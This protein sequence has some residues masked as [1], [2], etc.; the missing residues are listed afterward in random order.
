MRISAGL[1]RAD[2]YPDFVREGADEVFCGYVPLAWRERHGD[3]PL[4]RR[5]VHYAHVQIGAKAEMLILRDMVRTLGVPAA[6]TFN[7][8]S[9]PPALYREVE[10]CME[11]CLGMGF[12]SFLVADPFFLRYLHSGG[13]FSRAAV[14]LSGEC[15]A[16]NPEAARLAREAGIRRLVFPRHMTLSEMEACI[17]QAPGMEYEAFVLNEL[18]HFHGAWCVSLHGDDMGYACQIPC[19]PAGL[20][21]PVPVPVEKQKPQSGPGSSGC[22]LCALDRLADIGVTHLKLV[23][24]GALTEDMLRDLRLLRRCRDEAVS[25]RPHEAYAAFVM[26]QFPQGCPRACYYPELMPDLP[27]SVR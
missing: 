19:R 15:G 13:F 2:D 7:A 1:G 17:R 23:G 8:L 4:N 5:E 16:M 11:E 6:V 27:P 25:G 22:G 3:I 18:C 12:S 26:R 24:R 14:Y 20:D 21:G 9:Y 10:A